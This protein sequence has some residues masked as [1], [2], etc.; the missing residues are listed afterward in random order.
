VEPF[1]LL[2]AGAPRRGFRLRR[3]RRE[4]D[5]PESQSAGTEAGGH[6]RLRAFWLWRCA[7]ARFND[8][9]PRGVGGD[10]FGVGGCAQVPADR[11]FE[12]GEPPCTLKAERRMARG[13]RSAS[14]IKRLAG[15]GPWS[16]KVFGF[17]WS[18]A[19]ATTP[20]SRLGLTA[21]KASA[22]RLKGHRR[23]AESLHQGQDTGQAPE[24]R[25]IRR[26]WPRHLSDQAQAHC[27][28]SDDGRAIRRAVGN[29]IPIAK[30]AGSQE[31]RD[32]Q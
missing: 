18:K 2:L 7:R 28:N 24:R 27:R 21:A 20:R 3:P 22:T 13:R 11:D 14:K 9:P 23:P 6:P 15:G 30:P 26:R 5:R 25:Q 8:G 10:W 19:H 4:K 16:R 29:G 1:R 31:K 32:C 17:W 12:F